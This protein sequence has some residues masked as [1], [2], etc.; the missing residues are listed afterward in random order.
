M[1][2]GLAIVREAG[3]AIGHQTLA[4]RFADSDAQ[5]GLARHAEIALA[6]LGS[7]ERNH[8]I[9]RPDAGDAFTDLDND[10]RALVT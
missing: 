1:I 8:V 9:A 2:E 3:G 4:L 6:A 7:V 5:V 10:A